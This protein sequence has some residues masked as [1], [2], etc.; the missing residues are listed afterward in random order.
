MNIAKLAQL[1]NQPVAT[2]EVLFH[3]AIVP[4]TFSLVL[5]ALLM[6][7]TIVSGLVTVRM[8]PPPQD[9]PP[10]QP[11]ELILSAANVMFLCFGV[12]AVMILVNNDLAR[13]FAI[14]AAI[15]LVRFKIKMTDGSSPGL[16]FAVVI[17]MACGVDQVPMGWAMGLVFVV[18]QGFVLVAVKVT[19]KDVFTRHL[20]PLPQSRSS[21]VPLQSVNSDG[22]I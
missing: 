14:G 20:S 17:G 22:A 21:V 5:G 4:M 10:M 12:T 19:P 16:F 7:V 2:S 18:L 15:A 8:T 1:S 11:H 3:N 13:A 9:E 6:L